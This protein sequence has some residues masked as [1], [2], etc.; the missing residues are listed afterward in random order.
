L[1]AEDQ[2][3]QAAQFLLV[4]LLKAIFALQFAI[5]KRLGDADL[6]AATKSGQSLSYGAPIMAAKPSVREIPFHHQ[7]PTESPPSL[8]S[9][10]KMEKRFE[11][12]QA[13]A[14]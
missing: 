13:K 11:P 9:P 5:K 1:F 14:L 6:L 10:K 3:F 2:A 4:E 8:T 7:D 12:R